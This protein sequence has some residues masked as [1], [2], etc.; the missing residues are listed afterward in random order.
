MVAGKEIIMD[1]LGS[2]LK[3]GCVFLTFVPTLI[4][5]KL[6]DKPIWNVSPSLA[7]LKLPTLVFPVDI[8]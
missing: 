8:E 5:P 4:F 7:D 6:L 2:S 1:D 3:S